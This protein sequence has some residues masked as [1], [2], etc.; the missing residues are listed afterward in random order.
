LKSGNHGKKKIDDM[1]MQYILSFFLLAFTSLYAKLPEKKKFFAL[2][3]MNAILFVMHAARH[4]VDKVSLHLLLSIFF[5]VMVFTGIQI[6]R[7]ID[8]DFIASLRTL[9]KNALLIS[10]PL[11]VLDEI[12][13][14][15]PA[16]AI[17]FAGL[18]TSSLFTRKKKDRDASVCINLLK[19]HRKM[20]NIAYAQD[21][22]SGAAAFV[23]RRDNVQYVVFPGSDSQI[24]FLRTNANTK[25]AKPSSLVV[26][27]C[28]DE[29]KLDLDITRVHKGFLDAY[30]TIRDELRNLVSPSEKTVVCG[31]SLGGA[32]AILYAVESC[33]PNL[34]VFTFGA[35]RVGDDAWN[36]FLDRLSVPFT[37]YV[38]GLDPVPLLPSAF[39][40]NAGEYIRIPSNNP[41]TAH[42]LRE[43]EK[44]FSS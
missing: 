27:V 5:M 22:G 7:R 42:L 31:H 34:S 4:G 29:A 16:L 24:D 1:Q 9:A 21:R 28:H 2:F 43:Y 12:V 36:E 41:V 13:G 44:G 39:P 38:T 11:V 35:P 32:L 18:Y 20:Q 19:N 14:F 8:R 26:S 40:R 23:L 3:A 37:H 10:G 17:A 25:R 33:S 6:T 15:F 30:S